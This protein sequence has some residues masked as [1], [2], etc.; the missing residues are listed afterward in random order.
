MAAWLYSV[1]RNEVRMRWRRGYYRHEVNAGDDSLPDAGQT[2]PIIDNIALAAAIK[3]LPPGYRKVFLLHDVEG[4]EHNEI[5]GIL[6]I[7]DGSS[8][9]QLH[10]PRMKLRKLLKK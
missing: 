6:G 9:S 1:A 2:N 8:K 4:Y 7:S 10:K 5:S 3:K